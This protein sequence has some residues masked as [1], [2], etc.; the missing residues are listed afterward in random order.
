MI[1]AATLTSQIEPWNEPADGA[2]M[3]SLELILL[4]LRASP[5]PFSR[6][7]HT[8]GHITA[9]ALVLDPRREQVL[10]VHHRR[11]DRWL[12][13]G[14]HCEPDDDSIFAAAKREAVEETAVTLD[15]SVAPSIAGFD[16]HGIP[17]NGKEPYHLHHDILVAMQASATEIAVSEESRAVL[18]CPIGQLANYDV[19]ANVIRAAA[20]YL[21]A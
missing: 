9:T 15:A 16:V 20:R 10:L 21:A 2:A 5:D 7:Q 19:P 14:G 13:P 18:W 12:L 6:L 11:L 8:P 3:K 1:D 17:S 4:L